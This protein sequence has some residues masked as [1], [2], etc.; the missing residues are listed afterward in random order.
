MSRDVDELELAITLRGLT[1]VVARE[2]GNWTHHA[3]RG[4][5]RAWLAGEGYRWAVAAAESW[6]SARGL[7][8]LRLLDGDELVLDEPRVGD[9]LSLHAITGGHDPDVLSA[10]WLAARGWADYSVL[11][12]RWQLTV[13]GA[14]A[15]RELSTIRSSADAARYVAAR[16]GGIPAVDALERLAHEVVTATLAGRHPRDAWA[17]AATVANLGGPAEYQLAAE[18]LA[19]LAGVG[20]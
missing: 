13:E 16:T 11:L 17:Q 20:S 4:D 19:E 5:R 3:T 7:S 1:V 10:V 18:R 14:A 6:A 9:V 15:M 8:V 12:D 2:R